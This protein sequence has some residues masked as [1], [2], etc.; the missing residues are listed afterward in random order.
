[1]ANQTLSIA[2]LVATVFATGCNIVS[3]I[4]SSTHAQGQHRVSCEDFEA[5]FASTTVTRAG[6]IST[7]RLTHLVE[8]VGSCF[9]IVRD[10][11]KT[12]VYV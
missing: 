6:V 9:K 10:Q 7:K 12:Q 1:M 2:D 11:F 4:R 8:S 3:L 5:V